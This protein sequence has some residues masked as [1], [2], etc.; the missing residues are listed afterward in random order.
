VGAGGPVAPSIPHMPEPAGPSPAAVDGAP[1]VP[2]DGSVGGPPDGAADGPEWRTWPP[3]TRV[4]VR[5]VRDD[6]P[7]DEAAAAGGEPRYT[8]VLGDV[9]AVDDDGVVV[10]TR[11]GD[12][13]VPAAA[14]RLTKVVPPAPERRGRRTP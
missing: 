14:I 13:T 8:D 3:G 9:V 4:V 1:D 10:R 5:R 2:V 6:V 7:V 11:R 12:V